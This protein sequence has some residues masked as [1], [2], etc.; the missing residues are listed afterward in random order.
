MRTKLIKAKLLASGAAFVAIVGSASPVL[1]Q[2]EVTAADTAETSE[3]IV[4][5][6][7]RIAR[8][9][10]DANIPI[11]VINAAALE[12]DGAS[13]VQ[14][15]LREMPQVGIGT[16]RANSNFSAT[17]NGAASVDLRNLGP[18]RTL[19]LVNGRRFVSGFA[20]TS[21]VD[22]NNIPTDFIERVE[23]VTGGTSAIYGS[24]AVAGVVNF[25][26]KDKIEGI[27]ARAEY[28]LTSRGDNPRYLVSVTGGTSWGADDR[29]RIAVNFTHETDK[30]LLSRDRAIS[31]EDRS[32][33]LVGV[34][35][36]SSYAPQGR[37]DLR[38]TTGSAQVFTFDT[39]NNLVLGFPQ[40]LAYNRNFDR[41]ISLPVER[42]IGSAN[43]SYEF[44]D[45]LTAFVEPTYGKVKSSALLEAYSFDW[46]FIYKNGELGMPITNAYIPAAIR[47]LIATRNGDANPANDIAAI[48]FRR[49]QNE[50][51]NRSNAN[52]RDTWRVAAGLRGSFADNWKYELSYVYGSMKDSTNTQ[53]IDAPRYRAALDSV[54]D[55]ATNQI[56]CRDP[57]ARA[58]GCVPINLFGF[59]TVTQAGGAYVTVPRYAH[60]KNTQHVVSASLTGSLLTLPGGDLGI[61][62]GGEYR[63]EKSTT[64][65]DP[66]TNRGDGTGARYD[67]LAGQFDVK[68]VFGEINAPILSGRP[69]LEYLGVTAAA[70]YSDYSTVGTVL[71]W[72]AGIEYAPV[73]GLRF[74]A[75]YAEANRAPNVAELYASITGGASGATV[76]DPCAGTTATSTRPQDATCRAIPGLLQEAAANGGAFTYTSF[77]TNWMGITEGGNPNLREETAKTLTLGAVLTPRAIPGFSLSVDFFNIKIDGAV[78]SL[79]AQIL[80]NRCI[81]T[82]DPVYCSQIVRFPTG[83]LYTMSTTLMNVASIKTRGLDFNLNYSRPLGLSEDDNISVNLL[84]TRLLALEKQ[85]FAGG[86]IEEN[87]GQLYAA[88]RLGTGF[89]NKASAR[90]AYKA[91]GLT[92]SWQVTY[93]GKIQDRLG[94]VATG[95][96]K[97]YLEGLN[98]VGDVFYHDVQLRYA[99]GEKRNY[100]VYFGVNNLF[101]RNPPLIPAGFA[102]SVTG[103]ETA[104][105]YDPYGRRFYAGVRL[106]I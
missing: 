80:V 65:W 25:V 36:Y 90:I 3:A 24:D 42:Y 5:T 60:I 79:P 13:N 57:A 4:V 59:G 1:A 93:M 50:V 95:A 9:D 69:F 91:G 16:T 104:D 75:N 67:D 51:Y 27:T 64:D 100:E 8:P 35:A 46:S 40:E 45:S 12:Q 2:N 84:Y 14:D 11:A 22:L 26:L 83:K 53:D 85:S 20:G 71:S 72:N 78:G 98:R 21:A 41:R 54:L 62:V 73:R 6:G 28:G 7:S 70:R 23:V 94:Y 106:K 86:P 76:I 105:V 30:G 74:R 43:L 15:I 81:E 97:A 77:D 31:R 39:G 68:E 82:G 37:F 34:P 32:L 38:T 19:V 49:R 102:S 92:A 58:A 47:T 18:S 29:G 88:G 87:L 61:A 101:D 10:I 56:V 17:G 48:Q 52:T 103:V 96:D 99:V 89:K 63:K 33:A 55:P 66:I 44:S